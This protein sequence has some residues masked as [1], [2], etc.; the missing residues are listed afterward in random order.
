M[1][2]YHIKDMAKIA[3]KAA[4]ETGTLEGVEDAL[5]EYWTDKVA[6]V[7]KIDDIIDRAKQYNNIDLT[8][9]QAQEI[10]GSIHSQHDCNQ[11]INWTVID[12]HIDMLINDPF[13]K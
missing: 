4:A 11:G 10:L 5:T 6:I 9:D 12:V 7:W 8:E 3:A 13:R 1:Y 2:Q